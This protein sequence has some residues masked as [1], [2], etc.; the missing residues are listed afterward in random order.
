M[1]ER[2]ARACRRARET[3]PLRYYGALTAGKAEALERHLATCPGCASEWEAT[4][5]ALGA[6]RPGAAFPR[7]KEVDWERL[8]RDTLARA[9]AAD[10][11]AAD[12]RKAGAGD[13]GATMRWFGGM[14][15]WRRL[16]A[17]GRLP[18]AGWAAAAAGALALAILATSLPRRAGQPPPAPVASAPSSEAASPEAVRQLE[19]RLAR[20]G[21][22]RYL[23]DS[24]ALLLN[25]VRSSVP[26]RRDGGDLDIALERERA[27]ALLRR[28]NLYQGD[29]VR[30]ADQRLA[31]LVQQLESIL[32]QVSSLGDCATA[33]QIRDLSETIERRQILLRIDLVTRESG[34]RAARA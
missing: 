5:E 15:W 9:R 18:A 33:R 12:A 14:D 10:A 13:A 16:A 25:L 7:E 20:Q 6:V 4:R 3:M 26:C 27:R 8:G 32:V 31:G 22:T 23:R 17:L 34:G 24:R 29:L 2:L 28:K 11:R 1:S 21:A 19:E 30:P